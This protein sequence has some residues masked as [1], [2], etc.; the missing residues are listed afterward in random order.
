MKFS[1]ALDVYTVVT[2]IYTAHNHV[3]RGRYLWMALLYNT[4]VTMLID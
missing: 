1:S 2:V 4:A 3:Y